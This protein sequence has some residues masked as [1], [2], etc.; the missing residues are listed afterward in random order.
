MA[1][2]EVTR[3]AQARFVAVGQAGL[4]GWRGKFADR[5][6]GPVARKT[7]LAEEQI[8]APLG[9][10]FLLMAMLQFL[11]LMKSVVSAWRQGNQSDRKQEGDA[12]AGRGYHGFQ[13]NAVG[14]GRLQGIGRERLNQKPLGCR[15][16]LRG[17]SARCCGSGLNGVA[18]ALAVKPPARRF[19]AVWQRG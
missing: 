12:S 9:G 5:V 11:K 2:S 13:R 14:I 4:A 10:I 1:R 6:S 16:Y 15:P 8:E 17:P 18:N 19:S 7:G 3:R